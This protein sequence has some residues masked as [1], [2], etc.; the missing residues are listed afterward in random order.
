[1]AATTYHNHNCTKNKTSLIYHPHHHQTT[2]IPHF[3]GINNAKIPRNNENDCC[4]FKVTKEK[5]IMQN[6]TKENRHHDNYILHRYLNSKYQQEK[7]R[8]IAIPDTNIE[9][10]TKNNV[11]CTYILNYFCFTTQDKCHVG[12]YLTLR[13]FFSGFVNVKQQS[14][15]VN[16]DDRRFFFH[17]N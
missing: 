2:Q 6:S 16:I 17:F 1:M 9:I 8:V 13:V 11:V 10:F 3:V 15:I 12:R 5:L 4:P 14:I 7:G